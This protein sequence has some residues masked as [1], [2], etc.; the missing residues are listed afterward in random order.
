MRSPIFGSHG[1]SGDTAWIA[2]PGMRQPEVCTSYRTDKGSHSP[3]FRRRFCPGGTISNGL[4]IGDER[5]SRRR[6]LLVKSGVK[7]NDFAGHILPARSL[8]LVEIVDYDNVSV[9]TVRRSRNTSAECRQNN[10]LSCARR[11]DPD[12][13]S[14]QRSPHHGSDAGLSLLPAAPA[15]QAGEVGLRR[16]PQRR[17]PVAIR[18]AAGR[19]FPSS[20]RLAERRNRRPARQ[21]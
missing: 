10:L 16:N 9:D 15:A 2:E 1:S 4:S 20:A 11:P 5:Q 8:Q 3:Q 19:C 12:I 18:L 13:R 14:A 21:L 7:E 6:F 17:P